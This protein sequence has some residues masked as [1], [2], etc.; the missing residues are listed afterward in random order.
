M[1]M[2]KILL[3]L[4]LPALLLTGCSFLNGPPQTLGKVEFEG[5][6]LGLEYIPDPS[7]E[8]YNET[9]YVFYQPKGE[10]DRRHITNPDQGFH[11]GTYPIDTS[12]LKGVHHVM[13]DPKPRT[14]EKLKPSETSSTL[15]VNPKKINKE[16]YDIFEKFVRQ[17][18][19]HRDE[20]NPFLLWM[21][22]KFNYEEKPDTLHFLETIYAIVYTD[23]D[24]LQ[25]IYTDGKTTLR[26][27]IDDV[28]Y[29]KKLSEGKYIWL[30]AGHIKGRTFNYS[31][32]YEKSLPAFGELMNG[33]KK[34]A[35]LYDSI[36][37]W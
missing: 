15:Y 27:D 33:N 29:I 22:K 2:K 7:F 34:F 1:I 25:R 30:G 13:I 18:F 8:G 10:K 11:F 21:N 32:E 3:L 6:E 36:R 17:S 4:V 16:A 5:A 26:L 20:E 23:I 37:V 28:V 35:E 31:I 14:F 19:S 12:L 9:Y 24:N